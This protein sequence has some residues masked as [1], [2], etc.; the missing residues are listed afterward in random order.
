MFGTSFAE[1]DDAGN[2]AAAALT[3]EEARKIVAPLYEALNEPAKKDVPALLAKAAHPY[4]QSYHTNEEFLTR[5]QLAAVFRGMG[6]S[7][8]DLRWEI[9]DIKVLGDQI[10]VRG[11]ATG[12]PAQE[13]WGA[14]PTGKSFD[15]MA[16]DI[17]TVTE[18]KLAR[19]YH[20]ENW[21]TPLQQIKG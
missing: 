20:V 14:K 1:P 10:I 17:F 6:T 4:Y 3:L 11:Q 19:A 7:V 21:M 18:G 2:A 5:D 12:T 13:F 8:P 16:I 9:R 15:T